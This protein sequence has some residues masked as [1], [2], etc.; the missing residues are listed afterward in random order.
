[1]RNIDTAQKKSSLIFKPKDYKSANSV[2]WCPGCGD[3][4]ILNCIQKAMAETS[5]VPEDTVM[6]S[7]IGCSSRLTYYMSTYGIHSI[8]GRALPIATGIKVANPRLNVWVATG[9]GDSLAIGGNHFI[10]TIRRNVDLTV[11]LFNNKIYGLTKG[12]FSPTSDRGFIAKSAPFGT[13]EDPFRPAELCFGARGN[14]FARGIDVDLKNLTDTLIA[15]SK[16][17]GTSIVEVLQ[18]CV[19]FNDGTHSK[20]SDKSWREDNTIMLQHGE[21]MIF[22]KDKDRGI[23]VD[24]WNLKAITIGENGYSIADVLTHDTNTKDNVLQLKLALMGSVDDELPVSLGVIRNVEA[25]TYE[26]EQEKQI[27]MVQA[28]TP[29]RSFE[30]FLMSSNNIWEVK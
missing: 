10:H 24:G 30:E 2:R 21:K 8:H 5:L 22:G 20:L 14:F 17:K 27:E 26:V 7:G 3:H 11:V 9:D 28:K 29:K 1:M 6:V 12:Q 19:I 18:N 16:H 23:V 4:A 15:A 25:Q 13:V